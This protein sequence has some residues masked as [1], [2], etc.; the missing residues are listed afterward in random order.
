MGR[1]L[2]CRFDMR[3]DLDLFRE[4]LLRT[5]EIPPNSFNQDSLEFAGYDQDTVS[6]HAFLM[7][8]AG[9]ISA[10]F[11]NYADGGK[12][13]YKLT[14][15]L[16][17]GHDMLASIRSDTVWNRT[18]ERIGKT[19]GSTTLEIVKGVAEGI[20]RGMLGLE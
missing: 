1:D 11:I 5:E 2:Y 3:R 9:L 8:E 4:I 7:Y 17:P 14:R 20:T 16:N 6:E 12:E 13:L 18:K 19:V 15:L 10:S